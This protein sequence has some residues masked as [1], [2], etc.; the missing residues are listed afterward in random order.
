V[1]IAGRNYTGGSVVTFG[2]TEGTVTSETPDQIQVTVPDFVPAGD[3]TVALSAGG[4]GI[5]TL[6]PL[7]LDLRA[8]PSTIYDDTT[9]TTPLVFVDRAAPPT[10]IVINGGNTGGAAVTIDSVA[11]G[12]ADFQE[13]VGAATVTTGRQIT[14]STPAPATLLTGPVVLRGA[15][16]EP[17]ATYRFLQVRD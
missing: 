13:T 15:N 6:Q 5:G 8:T 11:I 9:L 7:V 12:A 16:G 10:D 1:K 14:F 17:S 3:V 2:G 4:T